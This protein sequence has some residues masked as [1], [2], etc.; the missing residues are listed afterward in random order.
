MYMQEHDLK[1]LRPAGFE[2]VIYI[3]AAQP[4]TRVWINID[5]MTIQFMFYF[6][7]YKW[8]RH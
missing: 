5:K 7:A 4:Y 3:Q 1:Y 6:I 8:Q 2:L